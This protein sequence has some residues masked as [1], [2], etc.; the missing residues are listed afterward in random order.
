MD[1]HRDS[2]LAETEEQT[3]DLPTAT[4]NITAPPSAGTEQSTTAVPEPTSRQEPE[5]AGATIELP[6]TLS[7]IDD[8][9]S[10]HT[11]GPAVE[12]LEDTNRDGSGLV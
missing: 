2:F 3:T 10:T 5:P 4:R 6:V 1:E 7:G 12:L 8:S 9:A 11:S